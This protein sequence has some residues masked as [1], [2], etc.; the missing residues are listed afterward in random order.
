[1]LHLLM[2]ATEVMRKLRVNG[3][4]FP[5]FRD[6][7]TQGRGS[8]EISFAPQC[9]LDGVPSKSWPK[10]LNMEAERPKYEG[11]SKFYCDPDMYDDSTRV[12]FYASHHINGNCAVHGLFGDP[13]KV[14]LRFSF[15]QISSH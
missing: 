10:T 2:E 1:M 3:T 7:P 5:N 12:V 14:I 8:H 13:A 11:R 4:S 9:L 15:L 6:I